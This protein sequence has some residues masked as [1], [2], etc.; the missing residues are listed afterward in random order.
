MPPKPSIPVGIRFWDTAAVTV[1]YLTH[2]AEEPRT[3][4]SRRWGHR[5]QPGRMSDSVL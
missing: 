1:V 3:Y 4:N 5:G 2:S